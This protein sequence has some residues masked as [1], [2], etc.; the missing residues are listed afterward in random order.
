[1]FRRDRP[2]DVIGNVLNQND[3]SRA[4]SPTAVAT[5]FLLMSGVTIFTILTF[6]ALRPRNKIVYEPKLKYY[7][8][9]KRPPNISNGYLGWI[10][11][12]IYTKEA[13]MLD[14]S[15]FDAV[16]FLRFQRMVRWLFTG[17]AII[18]CGVL[19]PINVLYNR[20]H[21]DPDRRDVFSTLTIRDVR[22]RVL[23]I[24]VGASY[25][26]T[27]CIMFAVWYNWKCMLEIRRSWFMSPEYTQS[28]YARTLMIRNVPRKYQSDEGLR[29]VLNA[30]QMPYP[31]TSVHIGRNV[32]RL[33]GLV[34][35]HNNAVRKLEEILVRYLKDGKSNAHRPTVRKGG[36]FGMGASKYDAIDYYTSKV[37]RSEAAIEMYRE[38]IGTCT[39][40]NYGFASMATV[41]YAQM[42]ARMLR[43][44]RPK[45]MTVCLAPHP[46]DIIWENIGMSSTTIAARKTLGWIYLALVCFLNTVP[47]LVVSFLANLNAM[48][49][50]VA[51]L[52]NWSKS[53]PAT[54]TIISGI[55]PPA[56]SAFFGIIFPVIM[57]WLSRFQGAVTRSRLDRAVIARYFAFLV[58]SQLFIF[59]LIGVVINSITE[60]VAQIGKHKSFK[61]IVENLDKLPGAI[62]RTYIDQ[63]NYWITYFLLRGFIA[64]FD[65]IQ[66][67]RLMTIWFKKRI[68]GRTPRDIRELSKP[69]RFDYADYYSNILFMCAVALAF[70]PLV[71]LMPVAAAVV[72]WIFSI[73]YKYQLIYAFVTKVESG[74]RLW[75]VVTNRLL[76]TV[77]F[78]QALLML[79]VGLQEGWKSFQWVSTLPPIL[80]VLI[81]KLYIERAF[82]R[83][84]RWHIPSE[85]ELRLAKVHSVRG[86]A[87]GSRLERRFGHP[88]LHAELFTPMLHADMMPLL[89]KVYNGCFDNQWVA[90]DNRAGQKAEA[91]GV[92]IAAVHANELEYD[93]SLYRRDRLEID[94]D[95]DSISSA[96]ILSMNSDKP[97]LQHQNSHF[98][99]NP[100][101]R[102]SQVPTGYDNYLAYGPRREFE[103]V[104]PDNTGGDQARL[105]LLPLDH[106]HGH[107]THAPW[108]GMSQSTASLPIYFGESDNG[109]LLSSPWQTNITSGMYYASTPTPA[110]V[111]TL[112]GFQQPRPQ[113]RPYQEAGLSNANETGVSQR[114]PHTRQVSWYSYTD[115]YFAAGSESN[116]GGRGAHR[117]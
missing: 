27:I 88:A 69:P 97:S 39:A 15:G 109:R 46:K 57:R 112:A 26:F 74:G 78:M 55:L 80:L 19:I 48:T 100:S 63:A 102:V 59:T 47:V 94:W 9:D 62:S 106:Q 32:G 56:V 33:Q 51:F 85:E 108:A 16:T 116:I 43:N 41:P 71:P 61:E 105:P 1:M 49:A 22:G 7:V 60:I 67:L 114:I 99:A 42:T 66:G 31:A 95:R 54:F 104:S 90:L 24:H 72:F 79:T 3:A 93:P 107:Q 14:K 87:H 17:I 75:N 115:N 50:Y 101:T 21:V 89:P 91:C 65:L 36:C 68:L 35:Y 86:D 53:N 11:P 25:V 6:N 10:P 96:G 12:L 111:Q 117:V 82:L 38:E 76:W 64:V 45:G 23:F 58:I 20:R 37:K 83:Q 81:F 8:R 113:P 77:V 29:I 5:Q 40:E 52:Q 30:M 18:G 73:V 4:L 13:E 84:F 2:D 98:Y 103:V 110:Q 34:D 28:F 70:A 44:K 92:K